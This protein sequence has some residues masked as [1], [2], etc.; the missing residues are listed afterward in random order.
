MVPSATTT[1][2]FRIWVTEGG[3]PI[4]DF[5]FGDVDNFE[6]SDSPSPGKADTELIPL[7]AYCPPFI[8]GPKGTTADTYDVGILTRGL[9]YRVAGSND[10]SRNFFTIGDTF[11]SVS[12]I[13]PHQAQFEFPTGGDEAV[14]DRSFIVTTRPEG[15]VEFQYDVQM[16]ITVEYL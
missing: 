10:H 8:I 11:P 14:I 12:T 6:I 15:D 16:R 3:T 1:A 5:F 9:C 2:E 7:G 13:V 4:K